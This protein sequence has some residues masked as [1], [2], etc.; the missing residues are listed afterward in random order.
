MSNCKPS[1]LFE[2]SVKELLDQHLLIYCRLPQVPREVEYVK[3]AV[4]ITDRQEL[5]KIQRTKFS[6]APQ[7][8]PRA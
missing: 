1:Y 6:I 8:P 2:L 3:V 4:S 5:K 7:S